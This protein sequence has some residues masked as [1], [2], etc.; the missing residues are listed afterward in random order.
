MDMTK[1]NR[2]YISWPRSQNPSLVLK[3][4]SKTAPLAKE[5]S[6]D[7]QLHYL[8]GTTLTCHGCNDKDAY[9]TFFGKTIYNEMGRQLIF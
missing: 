2:L 1:R 8:S 7:Q 6:R 9:S 3:F 5:N 4:K